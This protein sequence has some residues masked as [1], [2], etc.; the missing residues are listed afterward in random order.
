MR[1]GILEVQ[2]ADRL[3]CRLSTR[4]GRGRSCPDVFP[5]HLQRPDRLIVRS[6]RLGS[7]DSKIGLAREGSG[8]PQDC[9]AVVAPVRSRNDITRVIERVW[10]PLRRDR[11]AYVIGVTPNDSTVRYCGWWLAQREY[12]WPRT[13]TRWRATRGRSRLDSLKIVPILRTNPIPCVVCSIRLPASNGD[14]WWIWPSVRPR[15]GAIENCGKRK[16]IRGCSTAWRSSPR[17]RWRS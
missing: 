16:R 3:V 15:H 6:R 13:R 8:G 7:R 17:R 1:L 5:D 9:G 12:K 4:N 2:K 11:A 10:V 14:A